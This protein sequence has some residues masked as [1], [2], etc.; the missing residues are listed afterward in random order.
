LGHFHINEYK[1]IVTDLL[2]RFF[3][4]QQ[5]QYHHNNSTTNNN[6]NNTNS[7]KNTATNNIP[8]VIHLKQWSHIKTYLNHIDIYHALST[9]L[10]MELISV[11][12]L[13][14]L[15]L[16]ETLLSCYTHGYAESRDNMPQLKELKQYQYQLAFQQST[17]YNI[18]QS[19]SDGGDI[20]LTSFHIVSSHPSDRGSN[21]TT[22]GTT[23]NDILLLQQ[24][25][26]QPQQQLS[27]EQQSQP[28]FPHQLSFDASEQ[29]T[30]QPLP[31]PN[32][33]TDIV[34][35][36]TISNNHI[37]FPPGSQTPGVLNY[38]NNH[39]LLDQQQRGQHYPQTLDVQSALSHDNLNHNIN[40]NNNNPQDQADNNINSI[41]LTNDSQLADNRTT[42]KIQFELVLTPQIQQQMLLQK[43]IDSFYNK[44]YQLQGLFYTRLI[45][46]CKNLDSTIADLMFRSF[47]IS[48][49]AEVDPVTAI[50]IKES[51]LATI[52]SPAAS[53]IVGA[54]GV[55]GTHAPLS[56]T[57]T[58][59]QNH[60]NNNTTSPV[61]L[62]SVLS[63]LSPANSPASGEN[64]LLS[65]NNS[66]TPLPGQLVQLPQLA[67]YN[68]N[69]SQ[70]LTN[71]SQSL[72]I[73]NSNRNPTTTIA[74]NYIDKSISDDDDDSGPVVFVNDG[75]ADHQPQEAPIVFND[76]TSNPIDQ[77]PNPVGKE[78]VVVSTQFIDLHLVHNE[79]HAIQNNADACVSLISLPLQVQISTLDNNWSRISFSLIDNRFTAMQ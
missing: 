79:V 17:L 72:T 10:Y 56:A 58:P 15:A 60:N 33:S 19:S 77:K 57:T 13:P 65:P 16:L 1:T 45:K 5:Q 61:P 42:N 63:L 12:F 18:E 22:T 20:D 2:Q 78:E 53:T 55:T 59:A 7:S 3:N 37:A 24:Q 76:I 14:E 32:A 46:L 39:P 68:S 21:L 27:S 38:T 74:G 6:N 70:P 34:L 71:L 75:E 50:M 11:D 9:L 23:T 4:K 35:S 26:P 48:L 43:Q 36:T 52:L 66:T 41:S 25:Q 8:Q 51:H 31:L 28:L 62:T 29:T 64:V 40:I 73:P 69:L 49:N 30:L 54:M 47:S 44:V 67:R